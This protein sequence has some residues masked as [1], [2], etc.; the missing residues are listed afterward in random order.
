MTGPR[1]LALVPAFNEEATVA[2]VVADARRVLGADVVVID[3]GSSDRTAAVARAAGATVLALPFNLGVGGAIRAGLR[4]AAE[5]GYDRTI[6]LDADGQHAAS[7]ALALLARLD[8]GAADIVIGSR[9][10]AGYRVGRG[11][12]LMMTVLSSIVSRRLRVRVTDTTSGFRALSRPAI[13]AF[14]RTYPVDYLSDTVE[15]LLLAGDAG[16]S[17]AEVDIAMHQRRGGVPSSRS[18]KSTYH[19]LRV[20]LAIM[21]DALRPRAGVRPGR[22]DVAGRLGKQGTHEGESP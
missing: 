3:D 2:A 9:F 17:V 7:E 14:A 19:L 4:Y 20:L 1:L 8:E 16:L 10:A 13:E 21:V 6:Q 11:R 15:A 12:R 18:L 5:H 22:A